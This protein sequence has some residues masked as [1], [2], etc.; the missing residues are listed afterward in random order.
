[1]TDNSL[2]DFIELILSTAQTGLTFSKDRFD[3][4]R[5]EILRDTAAR[6]LANHAAIETDAVK[7]WISLDKGYPTPKLDVR[8]FILN[9]QSQILLVRE[10]SDGRWTLPGGWVDI[11]E[12]ASTA[13]ARE[14]FEETGLVC[15]PTQLLALFDKHQ[16]PHPPQ[17]P[18][19]Y[20][21][22]FLC[23]VEG[24][25][26]I[27][28]TSETSDAQYFNPYELPALSKHRVVQSQIETLFAHIQSN[29]SACLFD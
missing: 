17:L 21:A 16:H 24:G 11:G 9:D 6:F 1:M 15:K 22:F 12:S 5:F 4:E 29:G 10:K 13:A 26:L 23:V 25:S 20:K 2:I 27:R 14:V 3:I 7:D 8:A 28:E 18:H 19:A